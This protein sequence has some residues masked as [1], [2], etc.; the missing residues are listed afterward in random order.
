[1]EIKNSDEPQ[2]DA[3]GYRRRT[4]RYRVA[5]DQIDMPLNRLRSLIAAATGHRE[6]F[7]AWQLAWGSRPW[8]GLP[9]VVPRQPSRPN[10]RC[11]R[12]S[13]IDHMS[14]NVA[15]PAWP[16]AS[17]G[18]GCGDTGS[19]SSS[20]RVHSFEVPVQ[21]FESSVPFRWAG[22]TLIAIQDSRNLRLGLP[23]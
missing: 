13:A 18:D 4:A 11:W 19:R 16:F 12:C 21:P 14:T 2:R 23:C 8:H 5:A 6:R 20:Q 7:G 9:A 15:R 17:W 3:C 1:M 10:G 22:K